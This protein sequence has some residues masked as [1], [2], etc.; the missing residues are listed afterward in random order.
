MSEAAAAVRRELADL[1]KDVRKLEQREAKLVKA[2]ALLGEGEGPKRTVRR[3][4][5]APEET[6]AMIEEFIRA[7]GGSGRVLRAEVME[8]L[9]L[10]SSSVSRGV[11]KNPS[12]LFREGWVLAVEPEKPKAK[13]K[14]KKAKRQK[15]RPRPPGLAESQITELIQ[16][17]GPKG[18]SSSRLAEIMDVT[19][20]RVRQLTRKLQEEGVIFAPNGV[21]A[22]KVSVWRL[23]R[24]TVIVPGEGLHEGR[25]IV[26][27]SG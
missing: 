8:K 2:L 23:A 27:A 10:A 24:E 11:Q 19:L 21:E 5:R 4:R 17:A 12:L 22:G 9:D 13:P 15:R 25:R 20:A 14:P 26:D 18:I 3:P 6:G 7:K 1:R 16:S